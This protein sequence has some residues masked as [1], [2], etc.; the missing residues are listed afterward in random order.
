MIPRSGP[1]KTRS[2][3][4]ICVKRKVK[5]DRQVPCL[6]CIKRGQ[7]KECL[8]SYQQNVK[9]SVSLA[10]HND[11]SLLSIWQEYEYWVLALGATQLENFDNSG[12]VDVESDLEEVRYWREYLSREASFKLLDYA[13][14]ELGGF[15]FG[16]VGDVGEL[17]VQLSTYW[18]RQETDSLQTIDDFFWNT[19]LW[20]IFT[21]CVFY[22]PTESLAE[23]LRP[24]VVSQWLYDRAEH[25]WNSGLK[26]ELYKGFLKT[27]VRTLEN[28]NFLSHPDVRVIQS[29]L[30]LAVT[31]FPQ[32][33]KPLA[34]SLL[35]HSLHLAKS[36]RI[37]NFRPLVTDSTELRLKKASSERLWYRLSVQDYWQS[38]PNK[39]ISL[40][41]ENGSLL[42]H[43][44]FLM[45]KPTIDVYK[46]EDTFEA[47]MWKLVSLDRDLE[48]YFVQPSKPPLRTIEAVQKQTE[49][50]R[51]KISMYDAYESTSS[52]LEKFLATFL[53]GAVEWRL[54]QLDLLHYDTA[55]SLPKLVQQTKVSVTLIL[56]NMANGSAAYNKFPIVTTTLAKMYAFHSFCFVF[57]NSAENEQLL[58]DLSEVFANL[59]INSLVATR[60]IISLARRFVELR[61]LWRS[62]KVLDKVH[63]DDHPVIK[64]L[65][66]DIETVSSLYSRVSGVARDN[67]SISDRPKS[68]EFER[69]VRA[70]DSAHSFK[71]ILDSS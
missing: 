9:K 57:S 15:F 64:I 68:Q 26:N 6:N 65:Q 34:N 47:L 36:L 11:K 32:L 37:D 23:I 8:K 4:S 17:Y 29:Y 41:E 59:E 14:A 51:H 30:I 58:G 63:Q 45:D 7:D 54:F 33:H 19:I 70:F 13:V 12:F 39:P 28:A 66:S 21:M 2:P 18:S 10:F 61:K 20:S 5:C 49:I 27:A 25:H 40:H 69:I 16:C 50:F 35:V 46:S 60:K 53:L 71:D 3:C 56:G 48:R 52:K 24:A 31:P 55:R 1:L 42:T 43:A 38:G 67:D 44:A 22:I 62:I